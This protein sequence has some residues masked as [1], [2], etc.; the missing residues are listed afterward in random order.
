M[1]MNMKCWDNCRTDN[2]M[3]TG[4]EMEFHGPEF[5]TRNSAPGISI[6]YS[7]FMSTISNS[8]EVQ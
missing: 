7:P 4:R 6:P 5:R 2:I 1:Y 3:V 8:A